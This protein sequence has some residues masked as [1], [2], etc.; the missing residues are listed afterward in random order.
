MDFKEFVQSIDKNEKPRDVKVEAEALWIERS[1]D[2]EEAHRIVQ[3]LE[4]KEAF[5]VHAYLHRREGDIGNAEYWYRRAEKE[6]PNIP[7]D[8]EWELISKALL[9]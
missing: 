8:E 5:L 9:K 3:S 6:L 2:W 4:S 7:L 1:G